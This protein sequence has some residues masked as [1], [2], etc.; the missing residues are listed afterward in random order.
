LLSSMAFRFAQIQVCI[1]YGFSGLMKIEGPHWWRGE[2]VWDVLIN[3]Q[4]ARWDFSW[5]AAFPIVITLSTYATLL[6]EVYFPV[7]IWLKPMRRVTLLVGVMLHLGI[8]LALNLPYFA[9]VMIATYILFLDSN[10]VDQV[11]RAIQ[12]PWVLVVKKIKV[13]R[14][15]ADESIV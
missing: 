2:A 12:A 10:E 14:T 1:I 13:N 8:G 11:R 3:Q 5:L 15:M 7:L 9:G 4:L 6:W